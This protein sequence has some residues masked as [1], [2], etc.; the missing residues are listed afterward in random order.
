M[1]RV[2]R[3]NQKEFVL[4]AELIELIEETPDTLITLVNGHKMM[5]SESVDEVVGKVMHYKHRIHSG[6]FE[7]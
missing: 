7:K 2:S 1:I 3:L 5:V 4:N 6:S